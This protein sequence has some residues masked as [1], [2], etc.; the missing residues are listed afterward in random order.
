M[1]FISITQNSCTSSNYTIDEE[2]KSL[3]S[4]NAKIYTLKQLRQNVFLKNDSV[5]NQSDKTLYSG[6]IQVLG[7]YKYI[8]PDGEISEKQAIIASFNIVSG[9]F[10]GEQIYSNV[11]SPKTRGVYSANDHIFFIKT[12]IIPGLDMIEGKDYKEVNE[13]DH[14]DWNISYFGMKKYYKIIYR[15]EVSPI[16]IS[17]F[18]G[19]GNLF[20]KSTYLFN[21]LL[22][23]YANMPFSSYKKELLVDDTKTSRTVSIYHFNGTLAYEGP[24][25]KEKITSSG[26]FYDFAG[27][28]SDSTNFVIPRE[29]RRSLTADKLR[30]SI[31]DEFYKCFRDIFR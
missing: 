23:C 28:K 6:T 21:N 26:S 5:Y 25:Q 3:T 24:I 22:Y 2:I 8:K 16:D 31:P 15:K 13:D 18:W 27:N 10:S 1:L 20:Y 9:S 11:A 29:G 17:I 14:S 30:L 19:N 4:S 7:N 12:K